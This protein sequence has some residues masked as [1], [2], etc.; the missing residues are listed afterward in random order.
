MQTFSKK[1]IKLGQLLYNMS[2]QELVR[3]ISVKRHIDV[4]GTALSIE[5]QTEMKSLLGEECEGISA[6]GCITVFM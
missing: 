5:N 3:V 2:E 6:S 4:K 1:K